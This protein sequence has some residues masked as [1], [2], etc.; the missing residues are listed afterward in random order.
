MYSLLKMGSVHLADF[1]G[2]L[3][4]KYHPMDA[5]LGHTVTFLPGSVI[6]KISEN[7]V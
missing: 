2:K 6:S 1:Y 3:V 4:G 5:L 7:G